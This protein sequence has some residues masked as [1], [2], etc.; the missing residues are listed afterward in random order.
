MKH[1][2]Q[3]H[4]RDRIQRAAT[5]RMSSPGYTYRAG[6]RPAK[7]LQS[8]ACLVVY[9]ETLSHGGGHVAPAIIGLAL[10][11]V[12]VVLLARAE[13]PTVGET[14]PGDGVPAPVPGP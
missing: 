5:Q 1:P 12:G 2:A 14:A 4:E 10:A 13:G 8:V 7:M 11:V 3:V 6:Q 9:G